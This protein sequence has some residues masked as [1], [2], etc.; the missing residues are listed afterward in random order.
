MS[1]EVDT[2]DTAGTE[3]PGGF[4]SV[5]AMY[6]ALQTAKTDLSTHKVKAADLSSI[7]VERD[8]LA[9][10]L[11]EIKAAQMSEVEKA[12]ARVAELESANAGALALVE[13]MRRNSLLTEAIGKR[14][15]GK[16]EGMADIYTKMYRATAGGFKDEDSLTELLDSVDEELK[17]VAIGPTED[18][19]RVTITSRTPPGGQI[20][21]DAVRAARQFFNKPF[22]EQVRDSRK[23]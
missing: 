1:T 14:L 22:N 10:Q 13:D 19:Q 12:Q 8:T 9:T 7:Q 21:P 16:P 20:T 6:T 15:A 17:G 5:E 23:R 3:L 2:P 4:A 18:G 11:A